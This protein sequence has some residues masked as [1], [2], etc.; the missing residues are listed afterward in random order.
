[1]NREDA[2]EYKG[3]VEIVWLFQ[4]RP[5]LRSLRIFA[6]QNIL[7]FMHCIKSFKKILL[8]AKG[9]I[10]IMTSFAAGAA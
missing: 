4:I 10:G 8:F 5:V 1:M 7:F 6:V 3:Q 9:A 2:K